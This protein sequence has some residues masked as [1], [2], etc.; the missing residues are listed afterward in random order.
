[1]MMT[2]RSD[3]AEQIKSRISIQEVAERYGIHFDNR[4]RA[5]CPFHQDT[6]PSGSIKNGR[7]HCYVCN[8]HLD[9][10][11]FAERL[12]NINFQQAVLRL[13]DDFGL[14]LHGEKADPHALNEWLR[15]KE[16]KEEA[17]Q[18]YQAEYMEKVKLHRYIWKALQEAEKPRTWRELWRVEQWKSRLRDLAWWLDNETVRRNLPVS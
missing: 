9:I 13:D 17:L 4:N 7:Y 10:F 8:L 14:G 15:S 6:H 3:L 18:A 11:D 2:Y 16:A 1:M 12:F 5:L